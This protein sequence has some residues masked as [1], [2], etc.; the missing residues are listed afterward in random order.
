VYKRRVGK[1]KLTKIHKKNRVTFAREKVTWD[2]QWAKVIFSDEKKFN[3]DGPDGFQYYWCD[4]RKEEQ[5]FSKRQNGGGS[6]MVW[7]AFSRHGKSDLVILNGRQRSENYI[8]TLKN[9]LLPFVN[10]FHDE[11]CIFQHD[12][13]PIHTAKKTKKWLEEQKIDVI[14]WPALSPDLNPIE[15][16]WG[17][18][19]RRVYAS[20]RQFQNCDALIEV[21]QKVWEEIEPELLVKLVSTMQNRCVSVLEKKGGSISY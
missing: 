5:I 21:L 14:Q 3:L 11:N 2:E 18:L 6:V 8:N 17:V 20:G 1:P 16:V 15:N 19:A 13:A 9:H 7:A 4:L 12:N 10:R